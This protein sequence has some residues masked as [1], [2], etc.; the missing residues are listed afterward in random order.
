MK[1]VID[2]VNNADN[3]QTLGLDYS[4]FNL[5]FNDDLHVTGKKRANLTIGPVKHVERALL[6]NEEYGELLST[7]F[8]FIH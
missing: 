4:D 2:N 7:K 5:P 1:L 3:P 8:M 6:K